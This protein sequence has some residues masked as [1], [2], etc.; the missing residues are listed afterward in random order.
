MTRI[1]GDGTLECQDPQGDR[2]CLLCLF[3]KR[4]EEKFS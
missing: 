4:I 3:N 2:I 1:R